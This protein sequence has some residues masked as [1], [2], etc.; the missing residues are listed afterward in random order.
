MRK[1]MLVMENRNVSKKLGRD[2]M[3]VSEHES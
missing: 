3:A 2:V 1:Q